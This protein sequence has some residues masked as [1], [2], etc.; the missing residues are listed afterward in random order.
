VAGHG[1]ATVVTAPVGRRLKGDAPVSVEL[2]VK[3]L[4]AALHPLADAYPMPHARKTG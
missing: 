2:L 1:E 3:K 4:V